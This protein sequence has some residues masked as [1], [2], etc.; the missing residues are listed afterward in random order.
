MQVIEAQR[1][2][3]LEPHDRLHIS[4]LSAF[5]LLLLACW[6]ACLLACP[7]ARRAPLVRIEGIGQPSVDDEDQDVILI[8]DLIRRLRRY[9]GGAARGSA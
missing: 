8:Q 1:A 5:R 2:S 3:F 7:P 9:L 6:L 4:Q